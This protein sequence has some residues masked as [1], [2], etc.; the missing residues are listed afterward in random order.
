MRFHH[1]AIATL[2]IEQASAALC[3]RDRMEPLTDT[4]SD[5]NQGVHLRMLDVGGLPVEL[6]QDDDEG[7][8]AAWLKRG[9]KL[10]H[11]CYE[12]DDLDKSL[13]EAR[14]N[15]SAVVSHPKPAEL[16]DGRR[17]AFVMDRVMGLVE[18]LEK[19]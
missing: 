16:F 4:V 17:V 13:D 14:R 9:S 19:G 2:D 5:P 8:A 10:Y 7:P 1:V 15:G 12:V 3:K 11:V 6:V 18:F